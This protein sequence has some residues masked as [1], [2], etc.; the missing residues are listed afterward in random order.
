[1]ESALTAAGISGSLA[2]AYMALIEV[3]DITPANFAKKISESR[4]N[5]Y[6][7]LDELVERQLAS[8]SDIGKKLHYRATN[9]TH[10]LTL[11][12]E[13]RDSA[14][15]QENQLKNLVPSLEK[16][17]YQNHEQPGVRF[18]QGRAGIQ[19]I[20]E[21]QLREAKPIRFMKTRADIEFFGF[22]FMHEIRNMAPK[23]NIQRQAFTPDAPETPIDIEASDKKML[24]DRTWYLPDDYTAPVEWSVFGNKVSIISFGIV[25]L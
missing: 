17:Y 13:R 1:M 12:R 24:L 4:S 15:L 7:L 22:K 2:K 20:Y 16:Q 6:K 3:G 11:A 23:A 18:Y 10:L 9:P 21:E 8:R 19:E 5:S 25:K 14:E